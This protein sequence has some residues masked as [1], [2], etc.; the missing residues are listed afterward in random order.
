M[1][2]TELTPIQRVRASLKEFR[3]VVGEWDKQVTGQLRSY[4]LEAILK[5]CE[6]IR[7]DSQAR[8]VEPP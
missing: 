5:T 8:I 3:V 7:A 2:D 6:S 1:E 4:D